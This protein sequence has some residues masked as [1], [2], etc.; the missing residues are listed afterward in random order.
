LTE[1]NFTFTPRLIGHPNEGTRNAFELPSI[2][3]M[4]QPKKEGQKNGPTETT[5][6]P[7]LTA[8]VVESTSLINGLFHFLWFC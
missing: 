2:G 1:D 7:K 3:V 4:I 5:H 6:Q 8:E